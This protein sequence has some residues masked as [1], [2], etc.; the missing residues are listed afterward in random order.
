MKTA[1]V[2]SPLIASENLEGSVMGMDSSGMNQ[3]TY[4]LRDKIY[5]NKV[6]AVVREYICNAVDEHNKHGIKKPVQVG[7]R[8]EGGENLFFV[9]DF[10]HGL[11]EHDVRN[12][13]GMYFRSTKSQSNA[14]IGGFGIGSKAGHCYNDT[15]FVS[16]FFQNAKTTYTC[17]LGGDSGVPVG[18]IYEIGKSDTQESGLEIS[19]PIKGGDVSLFRNEI[20]FFVAFSPADIEFHDFDALTFVKDKDIISKNVDG[21]NVRLIPWAN[22]CAGS[23]KLDTY[24]RRNSVIVQMGGVSYGSMSISD[25][26]FSIKS[27]HILVVDVPVGSM[28]IPISRESFEDTPSNNKIY[29]KINSIINDLAE[30][31]L[32]QFKTKT[33]QELLD[34]CLNFPLSKSVEYCGDI[35]TASKSKLYADFWP[36]ISKVEQSNFG[37]AAEKK[38][39]KYVIITIPNNFAEKY[40]RSKLIDFSKSVGR[41]YYFVSEYLTS[42]ASKVNWSDHF[43]FVFAK[44]LDYP[45]TKRDTKRYSIYSNYG[46]IGSFNPLELHN[47]ARN[48]LTGAQDEKEAKKQVLESLKK[49][50]SLNALATYTIAN[51]NNTNKNANSIGYYTSS[52][53]FLEMMVKDIGWLEYNSQEYRDYHSAILKKQKEKQETQNAIVNSRRKWLEFH[54]RTSRLLEADPKNALRIVRFW[55]KIRNE[56]SFRS[57]MVKT[58]ESAGY[59]CPVYTRSEFRS[60]LKMK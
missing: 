5:S 55:Q 16:S 32:A 13:F 40:W 34:D 20:Q 35:F 37:V 43:E 54:P 47:R 21:F 11:N 27:H 60:I 12:V 18:H 29:A 45:K 59:S 33:P 25:R 17:M 4:F 6:L 22:V 15:F 48:G 39:G 38:N 56:S 1:V 8:R 41:N 24:N 14:L 7:F 52:D 28:S 46:N 23:A 9:R 26:S 57:K 51:R 53:K 10:A 19:I 30:K 44:K 3:A 2:S 36:F 31:D 50:D 49:A 58:F 42:T